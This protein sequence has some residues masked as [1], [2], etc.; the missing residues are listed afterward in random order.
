VIY[1][2][3]ATGELGKLFEEFAETSNPRLPVTPVCCRFIEVN[4]LSLFP[5]GSDTFIFF[6]FDFNTRSLRESLELNVAG[7]VEFVKALISMGFRKIIY[8]STAGASLGGAYSD[9]QNVKRLIELN[10]ELF[11]EV[12]IFRLGALIHG[13]RLIGPLGRMAILYQ[14]LRIG[15][16]FEPVRSYVVSDIISA[17]EQFKLIS[18][19]STFEASALKIETLGYSVSSLRE[20]LV[21]DERLT[22]IRWL[23]LSRGIFLVAVYLSS[24]LL[25][26]VNNRFSPASFRTI[27]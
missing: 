9:Y 25:R 19:Q 23:K 8:I 27:F 4:K 6:A 2:N 16:W 24:P 11:E 13:R 15:L 18:T 14:R 5:N 17:F 21:K 12:K 22:G 3:G 20:V 7:T 1:Y 10:L 26:I